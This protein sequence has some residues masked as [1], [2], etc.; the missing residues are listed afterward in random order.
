MAV[1]VRKVGQGLLARGGAQAL[2]VLGTIPLHPVGPLAPLPGFKVALCE[3]LLT[4]E[5]LGFC[6]GKDLDQ[7]RG[8]ALDEVW[9][10]LQQGW[11]VREEQIHHEACD[12]VPIQ[13]LIREDH[14]LLVS[15]SGNLLDFVEALAPL[16]AE[17]VHQILD[18]FVGLD[19]LIPGG[20]NVQ[21]LPLQ[22]KYT[23]IVPTD[24]GKPCNGQGLRR[25]SFC[26]DERALLSAL[27]SVHSIFQL[28]H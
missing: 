16:Q 3:E 8:E 13:I 19:L 14:H 5:L 15:Q 28:C 24:L 18:F 17:D 26:Q 22:G 25:V 27:P 9:F 2:V 7:G 23:I 12:V 6:P 20:P 1:H 11:P 4:L 21:W 10:H